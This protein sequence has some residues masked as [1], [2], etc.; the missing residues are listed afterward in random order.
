[1]KRLAGFFVLSFSTHHS[2]H[3]E[4]TEE[5]KQPYS[6]AVLL[7]L[8]LSSSNTSTIL[9]FYLNDDPPHT[10]VGCFKYPSK[11]R[12]DMTDARPIRRDT[13]TAVVLV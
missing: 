3:S 9:D 4:L 10:L 6:T 1:M 11:S 2:D 8:P 5:L 13:H 7:R 12:Q